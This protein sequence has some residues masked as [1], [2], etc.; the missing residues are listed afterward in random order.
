MN[1][2]LLSPWPLE[3]TFSWQVTCNMLA[4]HLAAQA[5]VNVDLLSYNPTSYI[6]Y[7]IYQK[8]RR[9][10]YTWNSPQ[11][12]FL[13][14]MFKRRLKNVLQSQNKSYDVYLFVGTVGCAVELPDMQGKCVAY[15][16][17]HIPDLNAYRRYKPFMFLGIW[18]YN[19]SLKKDLSCTRMLLTQNDWS[20]KRFIGEYQYDEKKVR[21]VK[22]GVNLK[23]YNGDKD[24]TKNLLLIVLRKGLENSKGLTL[25]LEAFPLIKKAVPS[26]QL[27]VVGT[28]VGNNI[29]GVT[30]Y[31][32]Q[33][34]SVTEQLFKE[35]TLYVMPA[36]T[37]PNGITFLEGLANKSPIVG[38]N[39]FSFPEFSGNGAWGVISVAEPQKLASDIIKVLEDKEKLAQMGVEGQ[40]F[41][42]ENYTWQRTSELITQQ[43]KEIL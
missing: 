40:A 22:F 35:S 6:G 11:D 34:R 5:N 18:Y 16:D 42:R 4:K 36:K 33:P 21:E 19:K 7:K 32:N 31:Y 1:I 10:V 17:C 28:D 13:R 37:E 26:A 30:C 27:A 8:I 38:L 12:L 2:C 9:F 25:L 24:Y 23:M 14:S 3:G 41:A 15:T 20:G 39:K 29:E 43:L